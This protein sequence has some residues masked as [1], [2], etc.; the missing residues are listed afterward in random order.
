MNAVRAANEYRHK[1]YTEDS[2]KST[3]NPVFGTLDLNSSDY[4]QQ[5][6]MYEAQDAARDFRIR[7]QAAQYVTTTKARGG[8]MPTQ[9]KKPSPEWICNNLH[10]IKL[11]HKTYKI[12]ANS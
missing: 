10:F 5:R 4:E 2:N 12:A 6:R 11:I 7:P 3:T 1:Y 9:Q 8:S